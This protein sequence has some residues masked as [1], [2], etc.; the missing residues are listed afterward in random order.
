MGDRKSSKQ[1]IDHI[2]KHLKFTMNSS[3]ELKDEAYCQVLKQ[4]TSHP[5]YDKCIRGWN[6]LAIMA[7]SFAPSLELYYS[8][9]NFLHNE[10]NNSNDENIKKHA[11]YTFIRL[12]KSFENK[13]RQI[14]SEEEIMHLENMKPIMFPVYFLSDTHTLVPTESYTTVKD[15]K[16]NIMRKLQ[17]NVARIPYYCLYEICNK[18]DT[19]EERFL[20]DNDKIVDVVA[21]WDKE[22][23][24]YIKRNEII[25]FRIYLKIQL[26]YNY[27]ETD[28]DTV[29]M[30][31]VQ[32]SILLMIRLLMK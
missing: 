11:N 12:V 25:E 30:V 14:P 2:T 8:I 29:T 32:V 13:R 6:F 1:P 15:L 20:D 5:D 23:E 9:L 17:F 22:K 24:D 4:I 28:N 10:A 27:S 31:Y 19:I 3:Q 21:L 7:A 18:K 26:F 16:T